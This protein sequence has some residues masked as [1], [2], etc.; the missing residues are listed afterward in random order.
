MRNVFSLLVVLVLV[1]GYVGLA[2]CDGGDGNGGGVVDNGGGNGNGDINGN[3]NGNG[4]GNGNGGGDGNGEDLEEILERGVD[5]DSLRYDTVITEAELS[6]ETVEVWLERDRIRTE[7]D[8][9]SQGV[10]VLIV[11]FAAGV[12][13]VYLVDM[14]VAYRMTYDDPVI[15]I[16]SETQSVPYYNPTVLGTE[17]VDGKSCLV[18]EFDDGLAMIKMWLWKEHGLPVRTE[19]TTDEGTTIIEFKNFDFSDIPDEMFEVPP[20]VEIIDSDSQGLFGL[21]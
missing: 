6:P 17:T 11:D 10:T 8:I 9:A 3:G 7:T 4:D 15:T 20:D 21:E 12:Q 18:I 19:R 5:I 2:A 16:I 14:A 13:Y 1:F